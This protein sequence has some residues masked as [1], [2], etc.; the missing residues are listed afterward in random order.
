MK[1]LILQRNLNCSAPAIFLEF[2]NFFKSFHAEAAQNH[3]QWQILSKKWLRLAQNGQFWSFYR[4]FH[5][6][7]QKE[8]QID[9]EWPISPDSQLFPSFATKA[10]HFWRNLK[11]FCSGGGTSFHTKVA[12]ND[13]Q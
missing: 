4:F 7:P 3:Q 10:S 9:S 2:F 13:P 6:F 11:N 8:A 1:T 12:Q 5:L